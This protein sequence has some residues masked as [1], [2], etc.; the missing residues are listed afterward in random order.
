MHLQPFLQNENTNVLEFHIKA[1]NN[2]GKCIDLHTSSRSLKKLKDKFRNWKTTK[3]IAYHKNHLVYLY[4][5]TDDNQ[6]VFSKILSDQPR[7][8]ENITIVPYSYSKHP[9]YV[10]P[11]LNDIDYVHEYSI[12]EARITNRVSVVIKHD[13]YGDQICIEYKHSANVDI[14]KIETTIDNVLQNI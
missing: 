10:F 9:T 11:C 1:E 6:I 2:D 8:I 4:D 3:Y 13:E 7:H 14:D 12:S 5:M